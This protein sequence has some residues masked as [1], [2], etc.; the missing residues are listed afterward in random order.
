MLINSDIDF[1]ARTTLHND[2]LN[3]D[4][5][6]SI[7]KDLASRGYDKNYYIQKF[8]DTGV[9][10]ADISQA[11]SSFNETLLLNDLNIVWR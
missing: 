5:I 8:Q 7:I 4:D 11:T 10:I 2:L 1:E 3:T 6:N 9:T